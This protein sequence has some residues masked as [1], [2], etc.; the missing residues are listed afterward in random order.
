MTPS[1]QIGRVKWIARSR[2]A[3]L[4]WA[5]P[6]LEKQIVF[7]SNV[8]AHTWVGICFVF[9]Y[10]ALEIL[11]I[12]LSAKAPG[13]SLGWIASIS[14]YMYR[15]SQSCEFTEIDSNSTN[16]PKLKFCVQILSNGSEGKAGGG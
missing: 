14:S 2:V 4:P 11:V 6:V 5:F 7:L 16:A 1:Q 13:S 3:V 12:K 15:I 10:L 9:L 8:E